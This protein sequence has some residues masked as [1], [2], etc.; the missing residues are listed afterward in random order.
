MSADDRIAGRYE[1]VRR[2]GNGGM[3]EVWLA[4]AHGD[5]GFSRLVAVKRMLPALA[6]NLEFAA[7]FV[8]EARVVSD[9]LH[10]FVVQVE[11]FCSDRDGQ[12]CIVMEWV[13]GSDLGKLM[14]ERAKRR[15]PIPWVDVA[16]IGVS[17]LTALH[18]AHSRYDQSGESAPIF[19]RDVTPS[20]VLLSVHGVAKLAD[21][22]LARAMDRIT[23]T[24]PG[25]V[26]GKLAYVSPEMVGGQ[27]ASAASDIYSLG[28]V[29][30]EALTG[31]RLFEAKNE[32]ELF[33]KVGRGEIPDLRELR[34][35]LPE[36]LCGTV[37]RMMRKSVAERFSS[38]LVAAETLERVI[39]ES[40]ER[41]DLGALL[42]TS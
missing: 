13:E 24:M 1:L 27:R 35:E 21:F 14:V 37:H 17:V 2:V 16:R 42:R 40:G 31:R 33:V 25:V 41:D 9:L 12:Y 5:A 10:P 38:A 4:R 29:M 22:G 18:A 36:A 8:E 20:N 3:A 26:K 34:P 6:Q 32:V 23:L 15:E 39:R 11:D 7:M 30:W 19:H 28:V